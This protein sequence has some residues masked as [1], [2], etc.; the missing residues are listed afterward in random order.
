MSAY[1]EFS[2]LCENMVNEVSTGLSR[3][4]D[5]A[6]QNLLKILHR[7]QHLGHDVNYEKVP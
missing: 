6:A 1:I 7:D 2:K 4:T 3:F 5:F